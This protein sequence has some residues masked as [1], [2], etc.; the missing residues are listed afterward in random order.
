MTP[1]ESDQ[2]LLQNMRNAF[3][4]V[5]HAEARTKQLQAEYEAALDYKK[6]AQDDLT[7]AQ[8]ALWRALRGD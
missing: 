5:E 7:S 8:Q 3:S 1:K 6:V 2:K 4:A